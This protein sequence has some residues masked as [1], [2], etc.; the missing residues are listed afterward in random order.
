MPLDNMLF[1][2]KIFNFSSQQNINVSNEVKFHKC[3]HPAPIISAI[4]YK[5]GWSLTADQLLITYLTSAY[6]TTL[7]MRK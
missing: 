1:H 5:F 7:E 3:T 2:Q 4:F 6:D